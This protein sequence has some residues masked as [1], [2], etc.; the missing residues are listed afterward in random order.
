MNL[1]I[2][3][4]LNEE[5]QGPIGEPHLVHG[6]R[7][8]PLSPS[9]KDRAGVKI[10][11]RRQANIH[12]TAAFTL[13]E[14]VVAFG[15]ATLIMAVVAALIVYSSRTF[16]A[17]SN[18]VDLDLH[19]RQ[20][21][22][23]ISREVRG[24]TAVVDCRTNGSVSYIT[25]TNAGDMTLT[26]VAWNSDAHTLSLEKTGLTPMVILTGCDRWRVWLY[27]RAPNISSNNLSF[28]TVTDLAS[29]KLVNMS[30]K[31]SRTILGSKINTES[32][33]TAQIVL[34]NKVN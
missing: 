14:A 4:R 3:R 34:R 15:L 21:L 20:A 30:W 33:Q 13:I 12:S 24:A 9:D 28:N 11:A 8:D 26:K 2:S 22:D 31:C 25:L 17:L 16:S 7:A 29:C 6:L 23:I 10:S 19:S 18:Y 5:N 32:V 27:N 1:K